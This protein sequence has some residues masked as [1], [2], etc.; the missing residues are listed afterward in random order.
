MFFGS[1]FF[2]ILLFSGTKRE[3]W[4]EMNK[5]TKIRQI[6]PESSFKILKNVKY[7]EPKNAILCRSGTRITV[8]LK[9]NMLFPI[10][11]F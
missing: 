4:P 8:N 7:F 6:I 3:D 2:S 10:N 5:D 11:H 9:L 1:V